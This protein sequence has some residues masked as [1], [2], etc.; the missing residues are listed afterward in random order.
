MFPTALYP[1]ELPFI[2]NINKPKV[3]WTKGQVKVMFYSQF[4]SHGYAIV[5]CHCGLWASLNMIH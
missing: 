1:E 4:G 5:I 3:V 2:L